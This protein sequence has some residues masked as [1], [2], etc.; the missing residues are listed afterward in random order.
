M[1]WDIH[2]HIKKKNT[3]EE[4]SIFNLNVPE[5]LCCCGLDLQNSFYSLGIHPWK[6]YSE[7]L[8]EH[9]R[10]IEDNIRFDSIKAVGECGMD[11]LCATP[12]ELQLKA[13]TGQ[14]YLSE[15]YNKPL[16]IHCVKAFDELFALKKELKPR[17]VWIIHGFRGKPEQM[18]QLIDHGFLLSFGVHFNEETIRQIPINKLVVETDDAAISIRQIYEKVSETLNLDMKTLIVQ[19]AENVKT[20]L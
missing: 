6:I 17:Q 13:F 18:Q 14:I 16:I 15:K 1:F 8:S 10:F 19:I 2:T 4:S 12:Q 11:K 7:L 9:L 5:H 3:K 20:F